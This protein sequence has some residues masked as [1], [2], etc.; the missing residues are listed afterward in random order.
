MLQG[1]VNFAARSCGATLIAACGSFFADAGEPE[2]DL[3]YA[4]EQVTLRFAT[5]PANYYILTG[6]TNLSVRPFAPLAMALP[7]TASGGTL[8]FTVPAAAETGF[9]RIVPT[10]LASPGDADNDGINDVYE[11]Q[12]ASRLG[13]S[14]LDPT[15]AQRIG[16]FGISLLEQSQRE[17]AGQT[18]NPGAP[19]P[20]LLAGPDYAW[21]ILKDGSLVGWGN[22]AKGQL[23]D[24]SNSVHVLPQAIG[25]GGRWLNLSSQPLLRENGQI[26]RS[27]DVAGIQ[28]DGQIWQWSL[29]NTTFTYPIPKVILKGTNWGSVA[30]GQ[31]HYIALKQDGSLWAWGRNQ[32]GQLGYV[33]NG[34]ARD[35]TNTNFLL[36]YST[37]TP[38]RIGTDID[39]ESIATNGDLSAAIKT[40][41]SLWLWGFND[42]GQL[43]QGDRTLRPQPVRV[44]M[45]TWR[46]VVVGSIPIAPYYFQTNATFVF[47]L[48]RD[49]TLWAWGDNRFGSLGVG[50]TNEQLAP[51][52]IGLRSDWAGISTSLSAIFA[53]NVWGDL[54][55]WGTNAVGFTN[56]V[57]PTTIPFP[58]R[59][60]NLPPIN[61]AVAETALVLVRTKA[62]EVLQ[63]QPGYEIPASNN[64]P[65]N[66]PLGH[67]MKLEAGKNRLAAGDGHS[68]AIRADGSLW[69]WG[70]NE[71]GQ[72][73]IGGFDDQE[74]PMRVGT[75]TNWVDIVAN[76]NRSTAL[77]DDGT[78][79][80]WGDNELHQIDPG[81][82]DAIDQPV[83]V[84]GLSGYFT[85]LAAGGAHTLARR[86]DGTAWMFGTAISQAFATN[87]VAPYI[88][89]PQFTIRQVDSLADWFKLFA[90]PYGSI[91]LRADGHTYAW[92]YLPSTTPSISGG[93]RYRNLEIVDQFSGNPLTPN[94]TV[95]VAIDY[96]YLLSID[97]AGRQWFEGELDFGIFTYGGARPLSLDEKTHHW[98]S[99]RTTLGSGMFGL[100]DDGSI[101]VSGEPDEGENGAGS[102]VPFIDFPSYIKVPV[103]N[104]WVNFTTGYKHLLALDEQGDIYEWGRTPFGP[105][106]VRFGPS[107][108]TPRW[109]QVGIGFGGAGIA[110]DGALWI[111]D[112]QNPSG[113]QID[114]NHSWDQVSGGANGLIALA[115][116]QTLWAFGNYP[117]DTLGIGLGVAPTNLT[118][119]G[120]DYWKAAEFG[121]TDSAGVLVNGSLWVWGYG[122]RTWLGTSGAVAI[123]AQLG[124]DTDW[125]SISVGEG[126][127]VALKEDG[128]VWGIGYDFL[129]NLGTT[130][131]QMQLQRLNNRL[132]RSVSLGTSH[133]AAIAP[134]GTLWIWGNPLF[135]STLP[136]LPPTQVGTNSNWS[137]ISAGAE[138]TAGIQ[139]DGSLWIWGRLRP[140]NRT[141][142]NMI[143]IRVPGAR[144]W[145][146]ISH[147]SYRRVLLAVADDGSLWG[148][149]WDFNG[150][151]GQNHPPVFSPSKVQL[152]Q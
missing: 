44:G 149:G 74:K 53:W 93:T 116:D 94:Q 37:N 97:G 31:S 98:N 35:R 88:G 85:H 113:L 62:G 86:R 52:R 111:W 39:W 27:L 4:N 124:P 6:G 15:D 104:H 2:V 133:T 40:D 126:N 80:A 87:F 109:H 137:A 9:F 38:V 28:E 60:A 123:P 32:Y 146:S 51:V 50:G 65:T 90:G 140:D 1:L 59:I 102:Y 69:A 79:W 150:E 33:T 151:L 19:W 12:N 72:L 106:G 129:G 45:D 55:T 63:W 56:L 125:N 127:L 58:T 64:D 83:Q 84:S 20:K 107:A 71:H 57:D 34:T 119:I 100:T 11:L 36:R 142:G 10:P 143:P 122:A 95:D 112:S 132:W 73:G 147:N 24:G 108:L 96:G 46:Q 70:R 130:N 66:S 152:G 117:Q 54:Y 89:A 141:T 134:D 101:Y 42:Y 136:N 81:N 49:G 23:G 48:K 43:A 77:Q 138:F 91:G 25:N 61:G 41:G 92:G 148:I 115:S 16:L 99:I 14:P 110:D 3:R 135:D 139:L 7:A 120:L 78:I 26:L 131:T 76:G 47:G 21:A 29:G 22:N 8:E 30:A 144:R 103:T 67:I 68:L 5:D 118:R 128:S 82:L 145:K 121:P 13:L 17:L 105:L 114:R 18:T 75:A